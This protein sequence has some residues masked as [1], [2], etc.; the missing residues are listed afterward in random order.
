[1]ILLCSSHHMGRVQPRW[2]QKQ[3][4]GRGGLGMQRTAWGRGVHCTA[5]TQ[6]SARLNGGA[7]G[8]GS[9]AGPCCRSVVG[10]EF[11]MFEVQQR[12]SGHPYSYPGLADGPLKAHGGGDRPHCWNLHADTITALPYQTTRLGCLH[13]RRTGLGIVPDTKRSKAPTPPF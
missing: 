9:A 1:M 3:K 12:F 8:A 10:L 6:S 13:R 7:G 2:H 11:L 4:N 5:F